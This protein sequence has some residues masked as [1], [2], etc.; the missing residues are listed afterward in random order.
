MNS[1]KHVDVNSNEIYFLNYE[2]AFKNECIFSA[3]PINSK[4]IDMYLRKMSLIIVYI[5]WIPLKYPRQRAR[6]KLIFIS[7]SIFVHFSN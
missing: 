3:V 2:D 4:T 5:V 7:L 6:E 1:G